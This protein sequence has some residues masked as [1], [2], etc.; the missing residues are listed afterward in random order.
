MELSREN[1]IHYE[2]PYITANEEIME[3]INKL[4]IPHTVT[5]PA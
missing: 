4:E 5:P 3:R 1:V 2:K